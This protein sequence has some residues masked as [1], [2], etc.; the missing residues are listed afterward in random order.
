MA[1]PLRTQFAGAIYNVGARGVRRSRIYL[2][3]DHYEMFERILA[4]VVERFGWRCHT[5]CPMPNHY[6]LLVETPQPNLS[7]G[8]QLLNGTHGQWFNRKHELVG[9]V[10]ERRF[11]SRVVQSNYHLLELARYIVLNPVRQASASIHASGDGAAT[12][13]SSERRRRVH[14]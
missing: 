7:H 10:F 1:R 8:M 11:Y 5:H 3:D 9:H 2:D 6:H 14:S 4:L 12:K 13:R